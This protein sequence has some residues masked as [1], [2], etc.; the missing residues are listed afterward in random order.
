MWHTEAGPSV[1]GECWASPALYSTFMAKYPND[2][3]GIRDVCCASQP[4]FGKLSPAEERPG[5][6]ALLQQLLLR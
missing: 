1:Q 6:Y 4:E 3:R 2:M 5:L